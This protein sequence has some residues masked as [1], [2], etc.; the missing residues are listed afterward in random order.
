MNANLDAAILPEKHEL[1]AATESIPVPSSQPPQPQLN[2]IVLE[3]LPV[4]YLRCHE[5][6]RSADCGGVRGHWLRGARIILVDGVFSRILQTVPIGRFD[7]A[8]QP[9][10]SELCNITSLFE[11]NEDVVRFEVPKNDLHA[12]EVL[13]C[14]SHTGCVARSLGV[15][16][17]L[18]AP[19]GALVLQDAS[20]EALVAQFHE[21]AIEGLSLEDLHQPHDVRMAGLVQCLGL[22]H[23]KLRRTVAPLEFHGIDLSGL[24][25]K[26]LEDPAE[27]SGP[28]DALGPER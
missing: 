6:W 3:K 26:D 12:M 7:R 23:C 2:V 28:K 17:P 1:Q 16:Q 19:C 20:I 25:I 10:V 27:R 4:E 13:Q 8:R 11:S 14:E 24:H 15:R 21:Q 5:P 22:P 9:K 18:C